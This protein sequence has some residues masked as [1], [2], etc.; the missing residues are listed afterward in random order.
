MQ[1]VLRRLLLA[2]F[3]ALYGAATL[4]GPAL[5]SIPGFDHA[6]AESAPDGH[7]SAPT[8]SHHDDCPV[9]HFL[10]QGQIAAEDEPEHFTNVVWKEPAHNLPLVPPRPFR[11]SSIPRAPPAV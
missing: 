2:S 11:R 5:H 4:C 10:A 6:K 1:R 7:D 8:P 9:C 3:V